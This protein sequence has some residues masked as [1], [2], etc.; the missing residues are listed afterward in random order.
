MRSKFR[1]TSS[2]FNHAEKKEEAKCKDLKGWKNTD[3]ESSN[4]N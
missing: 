2:E 4:S 3:P 1:W